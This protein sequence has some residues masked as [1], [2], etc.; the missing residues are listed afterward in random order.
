MSF[1]LRSGSG[2]GKE[3]RELAEQHE[4]EAEVGVYD[5]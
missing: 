1:G 4:V 2:S 5:G 3:F